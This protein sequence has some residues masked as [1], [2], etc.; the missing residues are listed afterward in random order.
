MQ[1]GSTDDIIDILEATAARH[2]ALAAPDH[3]L[4]D[5]NVD[6]DAVQHCSCPEDTATAVA[7][8]TTCTGSVPTAIFYEVTASK[9]YSGMLLPAMNLTTTMQIQVR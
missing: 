8:S 2:F 5:T 4:S 3:P 9:S 6:I 7:C 1:N